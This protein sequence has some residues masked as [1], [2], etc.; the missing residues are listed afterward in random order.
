MVSAVEFSRD[1]L[2]LAHSL[3]SA[4]G[5]ELPVCKFMMLQLFDVAAYS[6][7]FASAR[8]GLFSF[9][10]TATERRR[11]VVSWL[12]RGPYNLSSGNF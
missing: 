6:G 5:G 10:G 3:C 7:A 11:F 8:N 1:L 9:L 12:V 4:G 2:Y